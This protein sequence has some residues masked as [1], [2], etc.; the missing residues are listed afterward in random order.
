[1][2]LSNGEGGE[3][4]VCYLML[5]GAMHSSTLRYLNRHLGILS[6]WVSALQ[7]GKNERN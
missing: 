7:A 3:T 5:I 1:M 2:Q 6:T 4:E